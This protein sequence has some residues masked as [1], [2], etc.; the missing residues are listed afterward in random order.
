MKIL[1]I[2]TGSSSLKFRLL[3]MNNEEVIASGA[4]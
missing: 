1:S 2:N 3:E 4:I